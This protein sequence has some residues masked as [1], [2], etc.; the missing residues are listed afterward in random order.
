MLICDDGEVER[1]VNAMRLAGCPI[2]DEATL[3]DLD[4]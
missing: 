1:V 4:A 2:V 3:G